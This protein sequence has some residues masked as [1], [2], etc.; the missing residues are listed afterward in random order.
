MIEYNK[1][2]VEV[3]EI[4]NYLSKDDYN[5]IPDEI[6]SIIKKNKDKHYIWKYN[7]NK[8]LKDQDVSND[9]IAILSYINTEY[10]LTQEQKE[11]VKKLHSQNSKNEKDEFKQINSDIFQ[12]KKVI[13][14]SRLPIE[15][16]KKTFI[17]R[18]K[19]F[20][21]KIFNK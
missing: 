9:T 15:T 10:L 8:K 18:I 5:K 12:N 2:L 3:D 21:I 6:I 19:D 4:L 11:F 14:N 7:E 20:I 17:Q 13:N 16:N 1:R